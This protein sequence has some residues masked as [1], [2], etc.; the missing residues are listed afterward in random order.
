MALLNNSGSENR[1]PA[2]NNTEETTC[3]LDVAVT[4]I[5]CNPSKV[6]ADQIE[7]THTS[8]DSKDLAR[9][10]GILLELSYKS[11]CNL[12]GLQFKLDL[13]KL[14]LPKDCKFISAVGGRSAGVDAAVKTANF[15]ATN[16]NNHILI[17]DNPE[18]PNAERTQLSFLSDTM[19]D[20][21][22][23]GGLGKYIDIYSASATFYR[24][25]FD[26]TPGDTAPAAGGGTL[27]EVAIDAST[28]TAEVATAFKSAVEG[29][30]GTPFQVSYK[31]G[32][33]SE[34]IINPKTTGNL[35]DSS[36]AVIAG[37]ALT[38]TKLNDGR[39]SQLA[40]STSFTPLCYVLLGT[41]NCE[42]SICPDSIEVSDIMGAV[43]SVYPELKRLPDTWSGQARKGEYDIAGL[44]YCAG[45]ISGKNPYDAKFDTQVDGLKKITIIDLVTLSNR[46]RY[47]LGEDTI[48]SGAKYFIPKSCCVSNPTT[49][50][51]AD[52]EILQIRITEPNAEGRSD[53]FVAL[54]YNS[55]DP[56]AGIQLDL[57]YNVFVNSEDQGTVTLR[58]SI[59]DKWIS[60]VKTIRN[61]LGY[62]RVSR[63][64]AYQSPFRNSSQEVTGETS[65]SSLK[66]YNL[67]TLSDANVASSMLQE[68]SL[69]QSNETVPIA[70]FKI[71]NVESLVDYTKSHFEYALDPPIEGRNRSN[72]IRDY[73]RG[74]EYTGEVSFFN[75][76][77]YTGASYVPGK[78]IELAKVYDYFDLLNV[79]I[80]TNSRREKY[81]HGKESPPID[82]M[83]KRVMY[84]F[85]PA[86]APFT[87]ISSSGNLPEYFSSVL[88]TFNQ[89]ALSNGLNT[90][91]SLSRYDSDIKFVAESDADSS[92]YNDDGY[93]TDANLDG[94]FDVA[95]L[96]AMSNLAS[97][98]SVV[99]IA[100]PSSMTFG[101]SDTDVFT[102]RDRADTRLAVTVKD[103]SGT[104]RLDTSQVDISVP[105]YVCRNN[106][107]TTSLPETCPDIK[108]S[109]YD[110]M[111]LYM[112]E[113][114]EVTSSVAPQG[115]RNWHHYFYEVH[116]LSADKVPALN[117]NNMPFYYFEVW[118]ATNT[119]KTKFIRDASFTLDLCNFYGSNTTGSI[120]LQ[121]YP[122][123]HFEDIGDIKSN[124]HVR[125]LQIDVD[126]S[127][128]LEVAHNGNQSILDPY[129]NFLG[130]SMIGY[131]P[132]STAAAG[133]ERYCKFRVN[134]NNF[135]APITGDGGGVCLSK[136]FINQDKADLSAGANTGADAILWDQGR[137]ISFVTGT[138]TLVGPTIKNF[139][140][141]NY[142]ESPTDTSSRQFNSDPT[143]EQGYLAV[144]PN[145]SHTS[146]H[147]RDNSAAS[148]TYGE[149][150]LH[151]KVVNE[152]T[153]DVMYATDKPFDRVQ[154][155]VKTANNV[156]PSSIDTSLYMPSYAG[157]SSLISLTSS[158]NP[159][160]YGVINIFPT[161]SVTQISGS[162]TLC[163]IQYDRNIFD[164]DKIESG[165]IFACP[166][167][168]G[169]DSSRELVIPD[170]YNRDNLAK[171]GELYSSYTND[172][173]VVHLKTDEVSSP[174][175]KTKQTFAI[176]IDYDT[177]QYGLGKTTMYTTGTLDAANLGDSDGKNLIKKIINPYGRGAGGTLYEYSLYNTL[178]A[179]AG[180]A[181]PERRSPY[182][183][184]DSNNYRSIGLNSN[185][186][187]FNSSYIRGA[188]SELAAANASQF[189]TMFVVFQSKADVLST[190]A[191]P[192]HIIGTDYFDQAGGTIT[193]N[194]KFSLRIGKG[195]QDGA[196]LINSGPNPTTTP[197]TA[198]DYVVNLHLSGSGAG[199]SI[200]LHHKF[201]DVT[202]AE[203]RHI[204]SYRHKYD[205]ALTLYGNTST[206]GA[207]ELGEFK[208]NGKLA[209]G[210]ASYTTVPWT[211]TEPFSNS[212]AYSIGG[213]ADFHAGGPLYT[214][215]RTNGLDFRGT[216]SEILIFT[217]TLSVE[218]TERV[219]GYLAHKWGTQELLPSEHP[220][221]QASTLYE[222]LG[223]TESLAKALEIDFDT[224]PIYSG[225]LSDRSAAA[226]TS[227]KVC[228]KHNTDPVTK[229]TG[230]V[231]RT[232]GTFYPGYTPALDPE[233]V[234]T[235]R[236]WIDPSDQTTLVQ[237]GGTGAG[238]PVVTI[239]DKTTTPHLP[240]IAGFH[241]ATAANQ[242]SLTNVGGINFLEFDDDG[243]GVAYDHMQLLENNLADTVTLGDL[244]G[245]GAGVTPYNFD[246]F[247]VI[248]GGQADNGNTHSGVYNNN[249]V[250][251][252]QGGYWGVYIKEADDT[253]STPALQLL[254]FDSN[255]DS[256]EFSRYTQAQTHIINYSKATTNDMRGS[257]DNADKNATVTAVHGAQYSVNASG[258][259]GNTNNIL[260]LGRAYTTT[261]TFKGYIGEILLYNSQLSDTNRR[262]VI[263]YLNDKWG[264]TLVNSAG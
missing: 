97:F 75:G 39:D 100:S 111:Y 137:T 108:N 162:G 49:G 218:D 19:T 179:A 65:D 264:G 155:G 58:D 182:I 35:T 68:Y 245:G 98:R 168:G 210:V 224:N 177:L 198:S 191:H 135:N 240:V 150:N 144:G 236:L 142:S 138:Y 146:Y 70:I 51:F 130:N 243:P 157:Y 87:N 149:F 151:L 5:T 170:L 201:A 16:S 225:L 13:E 227:E 112:T 114:V 14:N 106:L 81:N 99:G 105:G 123:E 77:W 152:N 128:D 194:S 80:V 241:Q 133:A 189:V 166:P 140:E 183:D 32:S 74:D 102:A 143:S 124:E 145:M 63:I 84:D 165:K 29:I 203:K 82:Y 181:L 256:L 27:V 129:G 67:D 214:D 180:G 164:R 173:L 207:T 231:Y 88:S 232:P 161:G 215:I 25:W 2:A 18:L 176:D 148:H 160:G 251:G 244:I 6:L 60:E 110:G 229:I 48:S 171:R 120:Q 246:L 28:T 196:A 94:V 26:A 90:V 37:T 139:C 12:S 125:W 4:K 45:L 38:L 213:I 239:K 101:A 91:A 242:P 20:Y 50:C 104:F 59:S 156:N 226:Y 115:F 31:T 254:N 178:D 263:K 46:I 119:A 113:R 259:T 44:Y 212:G 56:V 187:A 33:D 247:M 54:G 262:A 190:N 62:D 17:Y 69:P 257:L 127:P 188:S 200:D 158:V 159:T 253:G 42:D 197:G 261:Y 71:S 195:G 174:L 258:N 233:S 126:S 221:K 73:K 121:P 117:T 134:N 192:Q 206:A 169:D 216:I 238:F 208:V 185:I 30:T 154:F 219:E 141:I 53:M 11:P 186:S 7:S 184:I 167:L 248:R 96:L 107:V 252:D 86:V 131:L 3:T 66:R 24:F 211:H 109:S 55:S 52:T 220:Y 93:N 103:L 204:V 76:S 249:G 136:I 92:S 22:N 217:E 222:I 10:R 230:G 163:R 78:S 223:E 147:Y 260:W 47:S 116:G 202:E 234:G 228:I 122:G 237:T 193:S 40:A 72:F 255:S 9:Q 153:V 15:I 36:V 209:N 8:Y 175:T 79:R 199:A 250:M 132:V 23:A 61:R 64:L 57:C 21:G 1:F 41:K 83:G 34:I 43:N 235:L 118:A 85:D 89:K 95:D 205:T 172:K